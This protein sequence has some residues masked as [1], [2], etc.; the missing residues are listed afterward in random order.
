MRVC[1]KVSSAGTLFLCVLRHAVALAVPV[2]VDLHRHRRCHR[3][4]AAV[5]VTVLAYS[6][7]TCGGAGRQV[8]QGSLGPAGQLDCVPVRSTTYLGTTDGS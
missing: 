3:R 2:A 5:N 6:C 1:M 4:L 8:V 7:R